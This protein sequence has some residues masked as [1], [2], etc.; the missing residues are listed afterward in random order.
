MMLISYLKSYQ[1]G[2]F[3]N[4][5]KCAASENELEKYIQILLPMYI[6]TNDSQSE[7]ATIASVV[8]SILSIIYANLDRMVLE[9]VDQNLFRD[10]PIFFIKKK[11]EYELISKTYLVAALLNVETLNE[12]KDRNYGKPYFKKS[13]KFLLEV[14]KK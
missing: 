2:V 11:F 6:F 8:P 1:K 7:K 4:E 13:L 10:N 5:Y 3:N 14:V 12:W 9:N